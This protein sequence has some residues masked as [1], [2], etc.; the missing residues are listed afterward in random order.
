MMELEYETD[1]LVAESSHLFV[2]KEV[3]FLVIDH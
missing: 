3:N 2:C 1:M